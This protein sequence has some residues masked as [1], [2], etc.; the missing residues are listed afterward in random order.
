MR[1][2]ASVFLSLEKNIKIAYFAN[3]IRQPSPLDVS[4]LPIDPETSRIMTALRFL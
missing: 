1:L 3:Y 2:K 4:P